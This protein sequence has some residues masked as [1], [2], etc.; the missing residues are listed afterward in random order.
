MQMKPFVIQLCSRQYIK[1]ADPSCIM[2]QIGV[3]RPVD[4]KAALPEHELVRGIPQSELLMSL[5]GA[6]ALPSL[7]WRNGAGLAD[8]HGNHAKCTQVVGVQALPV[9]CNAICVSNVPGDSSYIG[10]CV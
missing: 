5:H 6:M 10:C 3:L 9:L 4:R 7:V 8:Q 2:L 1:L